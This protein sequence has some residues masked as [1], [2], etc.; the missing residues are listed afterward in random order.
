[1]RRAKLHSGIQV[2]V[3]DDN[4]EHAAGIRGIASLDGG[5]DVVGTASNADVCL[6]MVK[7]YRPDVILM[8]I[9]MPDVD[10]ITLIQKIKKIDTNVKVIIPALKELTI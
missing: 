10:G 8:D 6:N 9:N 4:Y 1:M 3:V 7:K 2:L 5:F